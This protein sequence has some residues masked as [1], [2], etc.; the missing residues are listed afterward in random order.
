MLDVEKD[1]LFLSVV[2]DEGVQRVAVGDPADEARVGGQGD[3]GV[4]LDAGTRRK[5]G[6]SD[7]KQSASLTR[8]QHR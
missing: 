6:L 7:S 5:G 2:P 1:L 8:S 3:D 4:S